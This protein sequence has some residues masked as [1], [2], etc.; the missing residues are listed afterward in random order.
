MSDIG[1]L[2]D[3]LDDL[4]GLAELV[5]ARAS[6]V[7]SPAEFQ[8]TEGGRLR[9]DAICLVLLAIGES[10]KKVEKNMGP[11]YLD[12]YPSIPWRQIKGTRDFMAHEYFG[13]DPQEVFR[14]CT[15]DVPELLAVLHRMKRDLEGGS[16]T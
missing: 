8:A 16:I 9:L 14:T 5:I 1:L 7:G 2:R 10:V 6:G 3:Q 12:R 13:V 15:E 11:G 4:I